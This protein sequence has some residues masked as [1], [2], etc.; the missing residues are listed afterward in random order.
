MDSEIEELKRVVHAERIRH[1][2]VPAESPVGTLPADHPLAQWVNA[3][4]RELFNAP[5]P[6]E[7]T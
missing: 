1:G 7:R 3:L 6:G 4:L 2:M 5:T